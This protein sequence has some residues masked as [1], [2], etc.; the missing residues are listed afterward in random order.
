MQA[1]Q[2]LVETRDR[3]FRPRRHALRSHKLIHGPADDVIT[4][5]T[6]RDV[7][8]VCVHLSH[9]VVSGREY[10]DVLP[11]SISDVAQSGAANSLEEGLCPLP[12]VSM[13]N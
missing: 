2:G 1:A 9:V 5:D 7:F 4:A 8:D 6:M 10:R 11:L 3:H 12:G 13:T